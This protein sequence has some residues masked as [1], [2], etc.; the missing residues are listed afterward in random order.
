[1]AVSI[2]A[3]KLYR[4]EQFLEFAAKQPVMADMMLLG[5]LA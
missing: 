3:V 1:M 5:G 2:C 4:S